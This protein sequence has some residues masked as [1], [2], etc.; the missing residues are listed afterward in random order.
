MVLDSAAL[1]L[2]LLL[3]FYSGKGIQLRYK[4]RGKRKCRTNITENVES[5]LIDV[6]L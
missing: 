3:Y 4:R 2:L 1:L 5:D 6:A